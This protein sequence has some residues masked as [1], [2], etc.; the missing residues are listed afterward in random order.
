[1]LQE[2]VEEIRDNAIEALVSGSMADINHKIDEQT[3]T[4]DVMALRLD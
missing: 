3:L 1:M 2:V 4:L